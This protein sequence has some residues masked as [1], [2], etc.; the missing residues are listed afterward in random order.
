MSPALPAP[1]ASALRTAMLLVSLLLLAGTAGACGGPEVR[2]RGEAPGPA[3]VLPAGRQLTRLD[4]PSDH[5]PFFR[6]NHAEAASLRTAECG[7]CHVGLSGSPVDGCMDC[8]ATW[9]PRDHNLRWRGAQHGR[10]AADDPARCTTCH[11]SDVCTSCHGV[12]PPSHS[13]LRTFRFRHA[14]L[15]ARNPRSCVTCHTFEAT[16]IECHS[17]DVAPPR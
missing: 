1:D 6:R 9:R 5:T 4:S 16:C 12:A 14:S 2:A 17:L 15:A 3:P 13:P 7:H 10:V 8:H 11:E